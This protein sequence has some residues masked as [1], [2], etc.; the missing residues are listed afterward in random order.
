MI[1]GRV[2]V[3]TLAVEMEISKKSWDND[4]EKVKELESMIIHLESEDRVGSLS[5]FAFSTVVGA[6]PG[7]FWGSRKKQQ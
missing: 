6:Y 7:E 1:R 2:S 4:V 5:P 3:E